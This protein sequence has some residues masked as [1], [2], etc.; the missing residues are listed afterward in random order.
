MVRQRYPS[1]LSD[2]EWSVL[3]GIVPAPLPRGRP[4]EW[5]RAKS[6]MQFCIY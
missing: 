4:A 2:A 3:K 5:E 6:S 1:D